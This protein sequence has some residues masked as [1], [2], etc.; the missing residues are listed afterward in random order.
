MAEIDRPQNVQTSADLVTV[1]ATKVEDD[2]TCRNEDLIYYNTSC[3]G[4]GSF[5]TVYSATLQNGNT[6]V[7]IKKVLQDRRFKNRELSIMKRLKHA[8]IINLL[9]YFYSSGSNSR[10]TD[11]YLN[12]VMDHVP[13]NVYKQVRYY[14][15]QRQTMPLIYVK[16]YI[17]QL[18]RALNFIHK[19]NICHRDIKPQNLLCDPATGKLKLCDFGSAKQ[20]VPEETNVSYICSRYYRAPELI[21][22]AVQYTC[23]IDVWSCGCVLGELLLNQP[24]FPGESGVDQ[25]IEII[26]VLGTPNNDQIA[27]MNPQS[28]SSFRFPP[29]RPHPWNRVF[30]NRTPQSAL[31]MISA[32]LEFSPQK[33]VRPIIALQH[34]FFKELRDPNQRLPNGMPLPHKELFE[35]DL[36]EVDTISEAKIAFNGGAGVNQANILQ[37][38]FSES[39]MNDAQIQDKFLELLQPRQLLIQEIPSNQSIPLVASQ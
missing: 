4:Q 7:A 20:L 33:R 3:I 19:E 16:L 34:E 2:G 26:K 29:V 38:F 13:E 14:C 11:V 27:D 28:V 10:S 24:L 15:A 36:E 23:S 9:Y 39:S 18:F 6:L 32:I 30:R 25:L 17:Y 22:C 31:S 5:G 12:L 35:F 8:T 1:V 21:L 37:K